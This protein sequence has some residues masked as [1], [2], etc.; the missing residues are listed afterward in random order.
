ME[1]FISWRVNLLQGFFKDLGIVELINR[2]SPDSSL[3]QMPMNKLLQSFCLEY[4]LR[5]RL[6]EAR[7]EY[8]FVGWELK[9]PSSIFL[10][11]WETAPSLNEI[12][13]HFRGHKGE[14]VKQG[15]KSEG[16]LNS[17]FLRHLVEVLALHTMLVHVVWLTIDWA[18]DHTESPSQTRVSIIFISNAST[19][20]KSS[21][22]SSPWGWMTTVLGGAEFDV[23][24]WA[25]DHK[26][27][28]VKVLSPSN[29]DV[30]SKSIV[31]PEN[32]ICATDS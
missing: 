19:L 3:E 18:N 16:V 15:D 7:A 21:T 27:N 26:W 29:L 20:C 30:R 6:I 31:D 23:H 9:F 2:L 28:L 24:L 17:E 13:S 32:V 14:L 12:A 5:I 25:K 4:R 11:E 10:L 1:G 8:L 22:T